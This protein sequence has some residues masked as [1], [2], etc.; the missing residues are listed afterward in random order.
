M[1]DTLTAQQ[2]DTLDALLWRARRLGSPALATVLA[3]NPGLAALGTTLPAGTR[4]TVPA[5]LTTRDTT[6]VR[7]MVQ[8][9]DD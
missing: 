5:T 4:V 7:D 8:L 3:A 9:W 6:P 1:P 2:G